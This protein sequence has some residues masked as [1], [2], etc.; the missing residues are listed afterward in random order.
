MNWNCM[1]N[2]KYSPVCNINDNSV[3]YSPCH[4]GCSTSSFINNTKVRNVIVTKIM[5]IS[6]VSN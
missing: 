1:E 4:A 6:I 5:V 3:F 2:I